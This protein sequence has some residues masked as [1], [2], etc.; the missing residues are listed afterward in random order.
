MIGVIFIVMIVWVI[1]ILNSKVKNKGSLLLEKV[2]V[3]L[4]TSLFYS[5]ILAYFEYIPVEEQEV[6]VGYFSFIG[7]FIIYFLSSLPVILICGG[8]Y[9]FFA[10]LYLNKANFHYS[11]L[12]YMIGVFIYLIGGLLIGVHFI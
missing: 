8:F 12:K 6:N 4:M 5:L 3:A 7:L 10:E 2:V 1:F 9:S 11:F